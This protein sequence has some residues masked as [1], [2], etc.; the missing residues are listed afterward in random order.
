[1]LNR[2]KYLAAAVLVFALAGCGPLIIGLGVGGGVAAGS[3]AVNHYLNKPAP[4]K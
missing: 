1:M 3:Y 4:Q 2:V